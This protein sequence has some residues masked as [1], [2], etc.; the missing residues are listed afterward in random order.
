ME[1][2]GQQLASPLQFQSA[3]VRYRLGVVAGRKAGRQKPEI[4]PS[5]C[6]CAAN[7]CLHVALGDWSERTAAACDPEFR[8]DSSGGAFKLRFRAMA[9]L[10]SQ[11]SDG[12][13]RS[14]ACI[15]SAQ[16]RR[17]E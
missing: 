3:A 13:T 9:L 14:F 5:N 12:E 11:R 16:Q 6:Y 7:V 4:L 1:N 8:D 15:R 10:A 2:A 17:A